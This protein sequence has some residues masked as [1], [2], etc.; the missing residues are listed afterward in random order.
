MTFNYTN[1]ANT[2]SSLIARFGRSVTYSTITVGT[3]DPT[4]GTV[5]GDASSDT[6]LNA[7]ITK[8]KENASQAAG[9]NSQSDNTILRGDLMALI[10]GSTITPSKKDRVSYDG[11][12]YQ[13]I[14]VE[15]V[16]PGGTD[17]IHK[18]QLRK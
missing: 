3:Y 5:A 16:S 12:T 4:T 10:D 8:P 14:N 9:S 15:T 11:D 13:I 7:V 2:S 17:L 18:L 1:L 6:V